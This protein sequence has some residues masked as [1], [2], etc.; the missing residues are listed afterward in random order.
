MGQG[1]P[2]MRL[3]CVYD[4][5][6]ASALVGRPSISFSDQTFAERQRL[7]RDR[8]RGRRHDLIAAPS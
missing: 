4:A 5:P 1:N 8:R 3:V 7:A 2:T 6:L